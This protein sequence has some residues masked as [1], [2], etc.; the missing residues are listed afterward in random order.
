MAGYQAE[1]GQRLR[2]VRRQKGLTLQQVEESSGGEWKA[3][4]VGSYERGDRSVSVA[5]LARLAEFYG[6]PLAGILPAQGGSRA[7]VASTGLIVNLEHLG[8]GSPDEGDDDISTMLRRM[9]QGIQTRRGD[10]NGRVLSLRTDDLEALAHL[11]DLSLGDLID[12]LRERD[13]LLGDD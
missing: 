12:E 3:V 7:T 13:L 1:L 6:V 11:A 5:K 2:D 4:V 10:Y 9:V 8:D